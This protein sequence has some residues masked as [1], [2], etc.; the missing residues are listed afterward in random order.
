M[1]SKNMQCC[2]YSLAALLLCGLPL[3][4]ADDNRGTWETSFESARQRSQES[5]KPI[6]LVFR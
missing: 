4:G 1:Q 6:F 5:G 3:V 2:G